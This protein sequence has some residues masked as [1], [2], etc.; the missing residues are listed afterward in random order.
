MRILLGLTEL[1]QKFGPSGFQHGLAVI[2]AVLKRAGYTDISLYR[3]Q[4]Q[5]GFEHWDQVLKTKKPDIIGFYST[6]EQ[7]HNVRDL[8]DRVP[9][10]IFTIVG[11]P[12]PTCYP[13]CIINVPRLDAICIGE[14]EYP[15][16]ELVQALEKG[17]GPWAIQN[18]WVRRNGEIVRNPTR[19][20][21]QDLDSLPYAD[22]DLFHSEDSQDVSRFGLSQVSVMMS[23]G[24]PYSCAYCANRR[25]RKT[26]EGRYTRFRSVDHLLGELTELK[27]RFNF[28]EVVFDD[29]LFIAMK[30]ESFSEFCERYPKE[31]GKPFIFCGHVNLCKRDILT[32]IKQAGARRMDIGLESG[33]ETL[34]RNLMK[35]TMTNQEIIDACRL[36]K[37]V[38]LQVKTFNLVGV[39]DETLEQHMDTVALNQIINPDVATIFTFSPY[40][41]TDLYD[42]SVEKGYYTPTERPPK[43]FVS[44]RGTVMNMPQF[45]PHEILQAAQ[46]FSYRVTRQHHLVK[47]LLYLLLYSRYGDLMLKISKPVIPVVRKFIKGF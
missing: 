9:P 21:L 33:N 3:V 40:P 32:K 17:E 16:L 15:M 31:I 1:N 44:R 8:I 37:E 25:I 18:L 30:E 34:R 28:N 27:K 35:R 19:P 42:Y 47:A 22:Q 45:P 10:G 12:H 26:Q 39:P 46:L 5:D 38:G 2:S 36:A 13:D 41:G 43:G 11:G 7:F 24:C 20:F 29:D 4:N 6:A 23:R 14:G